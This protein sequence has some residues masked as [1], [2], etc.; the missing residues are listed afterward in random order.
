[1]KSFLLA[2]VGAIIVAG[3]IGCQC[4]NCGRGGGCG[5][6]GCDPACGRTYSGITGSY[7][8]HHHGTVDEGPGGPPTGAYAYPYYRPRGPRDFLEPNPPPLGP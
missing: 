2:L 4:G 6:D 3:S 7:A 1:M 5:P 8:G